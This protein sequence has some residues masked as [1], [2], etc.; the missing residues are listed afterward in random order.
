MDLGEVRKQIGDRVALQGNMDPTVLYAD[1]EYIREEAKRILNSYVKGSGHIFNLGHGVL[2]DIDLEN[3]KELVQ[4][5]K[6]ESI[7]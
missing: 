1:K 2:P 7:N 5:I 6:D 3:I 4:F